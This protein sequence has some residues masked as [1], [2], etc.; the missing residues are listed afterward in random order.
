MK[1]KLVGIAIIICFSINGYAQQS[2]T[3]IHSE[4]TEPLQ[5]VP[6]VLNSDHIA[7]TLKPTGVKPNTFLNFTGLFLQGLKFRSPMDQ[8]QSY[9]PFDIRG[10]ETKTVQEYE[11]LLHSNQF[12]SIR[13]NNL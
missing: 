4:I 5:F 9:S 6:S 11:F 3:L 13:K 7:I 12:L 8:F 2:D 1:I 10:Y